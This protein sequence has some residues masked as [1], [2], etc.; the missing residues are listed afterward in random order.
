MNKT[1]RNQKIIEMRQKG[2]S[3]NT[4][5]K[6]F[7]VSPQ[8]ISKIYKR[9]EKKEIEKQ[10]KEIRKQRSLIIKPIIDNQ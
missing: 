9:E 8:R 10:R 7:N 2:N 3:W 6:L 5:A 1:E 4:L